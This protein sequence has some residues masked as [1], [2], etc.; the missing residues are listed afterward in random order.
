M[1]AF[2]R[3]AKCPRQTHSKGLTIKARIDILMRMKLNQL[4]LRVLAALLVCPAAQ[5]FASW[6]VTFDLLVSYDYPGATSTYGTGLNDRNQVVGWLYTQSQGTRGFIRFRDHFSPPITDPNAP[7]GPTLLT[8]INN[9][10]T[11][12]GY[13]FDSD[14]VSHSFLASGFSFT[15]LDI[16]MSDVQV[17]GLN[18][19]GNFCGATARQ[20]VA[21]VAID[22]TTTSFTIPG[23]DS[24]VASG[25]NNLNRCVGYYSVGVNIYGF[26]RDAD[27]TL[28]YPI[29]VS[30]ATVTVLMGIN[31]SGQMVGGVGD[32]AG[33][34]G[35]FFESPHRHSIY[36]YPGSDGTYFAGINNRG[37]ISGNAALHS[38]G[39]N[40]PF[41][42]RVRP[43]ARD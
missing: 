32:P 18:D 26:L 23:A 9:L 28:T 24:T 13:Y 27:G 6:A 3:M 14:G 16:G 40:Q 29:A 2:P 12:C 41:V 20:T 11:A 33:S 1:S 42:A 25:I 8:N 17:W 31:D 30:G 15:E 7:S 36:D 43:V 34:H 38:T 10:A 5:I 37:I 35:I 39:Q 4:F 22:G 19:S 21:F